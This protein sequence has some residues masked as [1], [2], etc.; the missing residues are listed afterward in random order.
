MAVDRIYV[1]TLCPAEQH[2][3]WMQYR[4]HMKQ[5]HKI[6]VSTM[7]TAQQVADPPQ[8]R[9]APVILGECAVCRVDVARERL[10]Q[11]RECGGHFC[12]AHILSHACPMP[13]VI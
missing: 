7:L 8:N 1:C 9:F 2:F 5:V 3:T 11:C 10:A 6:A 13:L 4:R 12:G